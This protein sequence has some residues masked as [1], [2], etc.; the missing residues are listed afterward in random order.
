MR[1]I[2]ACLVL[3]TLCGCGA[4][5]SV[6]N[7]VRDKHVQMYVYVQR[8]NDPDQTKRP[9]PEQN[10]EMIKLTLKDMESLD[11]ILN[12]WKENATLSTIDLDGKPEILEEL[13]KRCYDRPCIAGGK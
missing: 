9:T 2:I 8:L 12:N 10:V 7:L 4:S 13:H 1:K 6:R 3:V 11:R 5:R